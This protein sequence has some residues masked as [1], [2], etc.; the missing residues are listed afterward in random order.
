V[1]DNFTKQTIN[2]IARGVGYRCSNPSCGCTTVA[3]NEADTGTILIGDAAHICAAS[4]GGP[5]Y[6]PNQTPEGRRRECN[7]KP[8]SLLVVQSSPA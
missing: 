8:N 3:A 4:P 5:R 2:E 7:C 1:R 6:D